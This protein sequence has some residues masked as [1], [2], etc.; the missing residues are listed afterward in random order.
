MEKTPFGA[1]HTPPVRPVTATGQTGEGR[2]TPNLGLS[3]C[4]QRNLMDL[5]ECLL[6]DLRKCSTK[7]N[8]NLCI[9]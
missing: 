9:M 2:P 5:Q 7:G 4:V 8:S 6:G 1:G 3:Q